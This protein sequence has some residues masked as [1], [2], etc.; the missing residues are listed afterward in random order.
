MPHSIA[1]VQFGAETKVVTPEVVAIE[2]SVDAEGTVIAG[3]GEDLLYTKSNLEVVFLPIGGSM[4]LDSVGGADA[5]KLLTESTGRA[6][7]V[8]IYSVNLGVR[9]VIDSDERKLC[10]TVEQT[11]DDDNAIGHDTALG[12]FP[13]GVKLIGGVESDAST[14]GTPETLEDKATTGRLGEGIEIR[15]GGAKSGRSVGWE[16][17]FE[18]DRRLAAQEVSPV[19][20]A[21]LVVE[22]EQVEDRAAEAPGTEVVRRGERSGVADGEERWPSTVGE[23]QV[24]QGVVWRRGDDDIGVGGDKNPGSL[25]EVGLQSGDGAGGGI[26]VRVCPDRHFA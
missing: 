8:D 12:I 3:A 21:S 19:P 25:G 22:T 14:G 13:C 16:E 5:G 6:T 4:A 23:P 9:A 11:F 1:N 15:H 26:G 10:Y 17:T 7:M 2:H 18:S 20:A 24:E